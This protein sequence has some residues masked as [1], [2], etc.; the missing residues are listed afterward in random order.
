M[1][2]LPPTG[3]AIS[4][5]APQ[6]A[7]VEP[8]QRHHGTSSTSTRPD[9][10]CPAKKKNKFPVSFALPAPAHLDRPDSC[11]MLLSFL[12]I[13]HQSDSRKYLNYTQLSNSMATLYI[14]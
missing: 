5:T 12:A 9:S 8:L 1:S 3:L 4:P 13:W 6:Q 2:I 7:V 11:A 10:C 14:W